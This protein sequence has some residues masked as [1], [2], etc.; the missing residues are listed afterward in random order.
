M[1]RP[2]TAWRQNAS[3]GSI[4]QRIQTGDA[5]QMPLLCLSW[6]VHSMSQCVDYWLS[7]GKGWKGGW[8]LLFSSFCFC[9]TMADGNA[10]ILAQGLLRAWTRRAKFKSVTLK[11]SLTRLLYNVCVD[12]FLLW[13]SWKQWNLC[14]RV[15]VFVFPKILGVCSNK[16]SLLW[17]ISTLQTADDLWKWKLFLTSRRS[18]LLW[19]Q[20]PP[21]HTHTQHLLHH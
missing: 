2:W 16:A 21:T 20:P 13:S 18:Q 14:L 11:S 1:A 8:R 15:L 5:I 4:V 3:R 17:L 12:G 7:S 6:S 19:G 9:N 10:W